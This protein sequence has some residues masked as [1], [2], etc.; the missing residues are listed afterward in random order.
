MVTVHEPIREKLTL[1]WH[2]HFATSAVKVKYARY[3]GPP[4]Q[5]LPSLELGDFCVLAYAMPNDS[6]MPAWLDGK[7]NVAASPNA[8]LAQG[9]DHRT[10]GPVFI[11]GVPVRGGCYGEEPSLTD[12]DDGDLKGTTDFRDI[13]HKISGTSTTRRRLPIPS[14]RWVPDAATV[15]SCSGL[16]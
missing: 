15:A 14:L 3:T 2:N 12:L 10:A 13:Y 8:N 5:K 1:V 9:T 6:A 4:N 16:S 7:D 11:A